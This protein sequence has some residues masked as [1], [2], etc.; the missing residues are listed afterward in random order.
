MLGIS[1]VSSDARD[2][3]AAVNAGNERAKLT[4]EIYVNRVVNVVGGYVAQMGG[5]D[6]I[7]FTAGLGENDVTLREKICKGLEEAF[8]LD[9]NYELNA[10]S[11]GKEICISNPESKVQVWVVPTNEELMIARDTVRLLGL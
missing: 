7:A 9:M 3:E 2:V 5:V 1:G 11:R 6:A 10:K 4:H 8:G